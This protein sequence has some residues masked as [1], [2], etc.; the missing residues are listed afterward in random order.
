MRRDGFREMSEIVGDAL[1]SLG[2]ERQVRARNAVSKWRRA[3]GPL[4][5]RVSEATFLRNGILWVTV[6]DSVWQHELALRKEE[7]RTRLNADLGEELVRD[8]RFRAGRVQPPTEEAVSEI[9]PAEEWVPFRR[10][11]DGGRDWETLVAS[12]REHVRN[13]Q[14]GA[15]KGG[16]RCEVCGSALEGDESRCTTCRPRPDAPDR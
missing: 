5:A 11:G 8:V 3:V 13:A 16:C 15:Q 12:V 14:H 1:R 7:I 6:A 4:L 2:V 10:S 9:D